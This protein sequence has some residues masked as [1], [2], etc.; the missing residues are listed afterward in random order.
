MSDIASKVKS[1]IVEKLGV[2]ESEVTPDGARPLQCF[3]RQF[4]VVVVRVFGIGSFGI[5]HILRLLAARPSKTDYPQRVLS[6]CHNGNVQA[7]V[8]QR[9]NADSRLA[10][11][12]S[13]V[14]H[15]QRGPPI[16]LCQTF[17]G[18][19]AFDDVPGLLFGIE[20][21]RRPISGLTTS[22]RYRRNSESRTRSNHARSQCADA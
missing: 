21:N 10:V 11:I 9:E 22:S 1:I 18:Q 15:E 16:Q 17:K 13:L 20:G 2:D 14:L 19:S 5:E 12:A 8:A 4:G 3:Q 7:A 6:G